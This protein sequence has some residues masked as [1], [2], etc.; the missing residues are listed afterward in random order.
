[1]VVD[2]TYYDIL[3]V[4]P[5][6]TS[7]EIKKAYRKKSIQEHPD[8]N[9]NNPDATR[10]F[11][12]ISEAYQVLSKEDLRNKY[13]KFGKKEAVPQGGFEDAA[14]EFSII[15]GNQAFES[16]IGELQLL[17]N[18][19]KS[20]E[21]SAED[22]RE[23]KREREKE[24]E[25]EKEKEATKVGASSIGG[26]NH[27]RDKQPENGTSQASDTNFDGNSQQTVSTEKKEK[28]KT[29]L[30]QFEEEQEAQRQ[31]TV[32]VLSSKL[33]ERLSIL[34]ESVYDDDCK[35]SFRK[36]FE[37]EANLLKM[38]SFGLDILHT[39]GDA[40]CDQAKIFLG[41]Q[42]FLGITGMFHSMR[43]KG[44]LVMDTLRTVSAALDAQNT[45]KE[46][47]KMKEAT[48]SDEPLLDKRGNE[49]PKPTTEQ[50]AEQE[51]ILMGKVLS[52]AWFGSKFEIM[53]T[54]KSVCNKVLQDKSV[55]LET[56]IRRA[57]ALKILGKVFQSA[58]RTKSEQEE[59]QVFEELV[60]EAT[61]KTKSSK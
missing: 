33:I 41:S 25:K 1:M 18:L 4:S 6:A 50:L 38:E 22:E 46:L 44:G 7:L 30:E 54:L 43:S 52:A 21:L 40:Y 39:I 56:R 12:E 10:R 13:D 9:P 15:F 16:Y 37:E 51:Q 29:K 11:Q 58:Y 5:T 59:A 61:K 48:Q 31:K 49:Q 28:K 53:S 47:E 35:E 57:E 26:D 42:Q 8:K 45:L 2:T 20:E 36:K 55:P 34:T 14:E 3:G 32:E 17:K 23:R 27:D 19:Q 60:A 24:K